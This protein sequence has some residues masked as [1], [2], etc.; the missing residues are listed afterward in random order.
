MTT[1]PLRLGLYPSTI[2][3]S[4]DNTRYI[5]STIS[6]G[7]KKTISVHEFP[8]RKEERRN[9]GENSPNHFLMRF[10]LRTSGLGRKNRKKKVSQRQC[11]TGVWRAA[12]PPRRTFWLA[13]CYKPQHSSLSLRKQMHWKGTS[14]SD[15]QSSQVPALRHTGLLDSPQMI[16]DGKGIYGDR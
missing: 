6:S 15:V 12:V 5:Q 1:A 3:S 2:R 13:W 14:F 9:A 11:V 10:D 4:N 16:V 8:R 7:K